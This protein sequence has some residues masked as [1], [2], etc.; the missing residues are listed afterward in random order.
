MHLV[1]KSSNSKSQ[2]P[3]SAN[4]GTTAPI[5]STSGTR[6]SGGQQPT[7]RNS[8][9][10]GNPS[11]QRFLR[12]PN[13]VVNPACAES[14]SEQRACNITGCCLSSLTE[15]GIGASHIWGWGCLAECYRPTIL[16]DQAIPD[17]KC[18]L[19]YKLYYY[20]PTSL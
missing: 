12:D 16:H 4:M 1:P 18:Y 13:Q 5:L 10:T 14:C 8:E 19:G 17:R 9:R 3:T 11:H 7:T 2:L 6:P 15:R 20:I